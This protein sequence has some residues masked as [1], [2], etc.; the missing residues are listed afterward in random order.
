MLLFLTL[1]NKTKMY[2]IWLSWTHSHAILLLSK[3]TPTKCLPSLFLHQDLEPCGFFLGVGRKGYNHIF[4]SRQPKF[5]FAFNTFL[6]KLIHTL[7]YQGQSA[8]N[9]TAPNVWKCISV[10]RTLFHG[11][12]S[13][14]ITSVALDKHWKLIPPKFS[15]SLKVVNLSPQYPSTLSSWEKWVYNWT[16]A[17]RHAKSCFIKLNGETHTCYS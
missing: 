3:P 4:E 9:P 16:N 6:Q 2:N 11:K 17:R 5:P 8:R 7:D 10:R 13:A 12:L 15:A 1:K 14:E